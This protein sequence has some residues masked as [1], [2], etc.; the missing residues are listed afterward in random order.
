MG[1]S[2]AAGEPDGAEVDVGASVALGAG[3]RAGDVGAVDGA[4][5]GVGELDTGATVGAVE[6]QAASPSARTTTAVEMIDLAERRSD[7]LCICATPALLGPFHQRRSC[8]S[9]VLRGGS[10][11]VHETRLPTPCCAE[12][13]R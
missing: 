4:I 10:R 6:S 5:D 7:S 8:T 9:T 12:H 13:P 3:V 1:G 11:R 2:L